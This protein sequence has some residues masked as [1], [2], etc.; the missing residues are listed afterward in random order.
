[1]ADV[2]HRVVAGH[3]LLLQEIG[4]V[5]LTLGKNRHEHVGAC[6]FLPPGR[7][8]MDH[9]TLDHALKTRRGLGIFAPVTDEIVE[10]LVNIVAEVLPQQFDID[11]TGPQHRR[12]VVV[13]GQAQ[14]QVFER[15][16]FM[17][18]LVGDRKSAMQR[19]FEIAREGRH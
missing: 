19:L 18:T 15:R 6:D 14:K 7:L 10:L 1:M 4:G 8:H 11:G 17:M 13:F 12:R 2:I 16:I 9:R 5:A 3:I